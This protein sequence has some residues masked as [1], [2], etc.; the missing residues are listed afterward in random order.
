MEKTIKIMVAFLLIAAL[1]SYCVLW[2]KIF[3]LG[4]YYMNATVF[5]TVLYGASPIILGYFLYKLIKWMF[6]TQ[7]N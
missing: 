6:K 2:F 3:Y 7:F 1:I 4:N 5:M